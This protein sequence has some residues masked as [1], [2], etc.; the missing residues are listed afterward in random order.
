MSYGEDTYELLERL[1]CLKD[2]NLNITGLRIHTL[3]DLDEGL[4]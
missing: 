3:P 4:E 1:A 2:G